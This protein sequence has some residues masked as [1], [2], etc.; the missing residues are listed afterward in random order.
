MNRKPYPTDLTNSSKMKIWLWSAVG[1][2]MINLVVVGIVAFLIHRDS[3]QYQPNS[4]PNEQR[5][6]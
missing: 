6:I 3:V 5:Q 1:I 2:L 4:L